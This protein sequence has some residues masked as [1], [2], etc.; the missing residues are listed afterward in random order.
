M[1]FLYT[2]ITMLNFFSQNAAK[3]FGIAENRLSK[4]YF[5]VIRQVSDKLLITVIREGPALH[6]SFVFEKFGYTR[7]KLAF[8]RDF[9]GLRV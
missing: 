6:Y 5:C 3:N 8:T 7:V 4:F 2:A 9:T 1:Y